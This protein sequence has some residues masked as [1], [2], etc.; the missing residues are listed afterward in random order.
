MTPLGPPTRLRFKMVDWLITGPSTIMTGPSTQVW[1]MSFR[2]IIMIY[3]YIYIYRY[4]RPYPCIPCTEGGARME[5]VEPGGVC[6]RF[7]PETPKTLRTQK[8]HSNLYNIYIYICIYIKY[9]ALCTCVYVC[10]IGVPCV[11]CFI[12]VCIGVPCVYFRCIAY[13]LF[14]VIVVNF[15]LSNNT[16][17]TSNKFI[18]C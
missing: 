13:A 16:R 14:I 6:Q 7:A 18:A 15:F 8:T 9:M 3:I 17:T 4:T 12:G 5:P 2:D 1:L 11:L 10:C